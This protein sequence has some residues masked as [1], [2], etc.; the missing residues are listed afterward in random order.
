M[1]L[2]DSNGLPLSVH[3]EGGN[4]HDIV[5]TDATL[6]AAFVPYLPEN[7]IGDKA[8]DSL[9]LQERL[10]EERGIVL[11]AP[12]REGGKRK[13]DRRRFRRYKR[14]WLVER[15]FA[16]LK[17]FRRVATRWEH[18]ADNY[19]GMLHLACIMILLRQ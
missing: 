11:I 13:Q 5:L 7:L 19:L 10:L 16:W 6:D 12:V 4:R 3:I 18:K 9:G 1:A 17:K 15:L 2:A 8:W 14:R